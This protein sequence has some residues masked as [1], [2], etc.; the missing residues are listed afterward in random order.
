MNVPEDEDRRA[1][2]RDGPDKVEA[3]EPRRLRSERA[4]HASPDPQEKKG[5]E[6]QCRDGEQRRR[7][8]AVESHNPPEVRSKESDE[9]GEKACVQPRWRDRARGRLVPTQEAAHPDGRVAED[10]AAN[11]GHRDPE[12]SA[13]RRAAKEYESGDRQEHEDN[14]LVHPPA[15]SSEE[16]ENEMASGAVQEGTRP[17]QGA[18]RQEE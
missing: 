16:P 4:I 18:G 7:R 8:K 11:H 12:E 15:D 3:F 6:D 13:N 1:Q 2:P 17:G 10:A 9:T 14:R 5:E